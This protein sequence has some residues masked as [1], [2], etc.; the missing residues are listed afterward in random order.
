[1]LLKTSGSSTEFRLL[2]RTQTIERFIAR[3]DDVLCLASDLAGA[4]KN[5]A[6]YNT[7][8][9]PCP[10]IDLPILE[11]CATCRRTRQQPDDGP[12]SGHAAE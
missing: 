4:R 12:R 3:I 6:G 7:G 11:R 5:E 8:F 2:I 1:M 10:A 9:V